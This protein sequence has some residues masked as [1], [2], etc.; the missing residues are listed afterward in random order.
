MLR[1]LPSLYK[2]SGVFLTIALLTIE[3]QW[4]QP[5][6]AQSTRKF[7]CEVLGGS[8]T[9]VVQTVRGSIPMIH[10]V[11]SFTGRYNNVDRRCNEV[12]NRL[13]RFDRAGKLKYIRTGN[14]NTYP[15]LCVDAGISGNTCPKS[16]VLVT[17]PK[18]T[19]SAHMLQ[20]MLDLRARASGRIIQLSGEQLV[21][22]RNGDAYVNI[23]RLLAR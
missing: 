3:S 18:G 11:K 8:P 17:L 12:S 22:Y 14:V 2:F 16:S 20:Q 6:Q 9:T 10:W 19:D 15:V 13:D 21:R 1:I 4:L 7:S 23:D 5:S